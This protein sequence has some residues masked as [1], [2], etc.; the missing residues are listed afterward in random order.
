M[1][2]RAALAAGWLF[3]ALPA[4]AIDV[5]LLHVN[6]VYQM[7]PAADGRG[8]LAR[9]QTL[10]RRLQA[11]ESGRVLFTFGGDTL[12]PSVLGNEFKGAPL[13]AAW[14]AMGIDA[15]VLGNHEFDYGP[16]VLQSRLAESRFPWLA[17]NVDGGDAG[18]PFPGTRPYVIREVGGLRI[19]FVGVVTASTPRVSHPGQDVEF[20]DPL[21][22]ARRLADRLRKRDKVDAVVALTHLDL[23][24]DRRLAGSRKVDLILGGHDHFVVSEVTGGTPIFKAGMDA[25]DAVIARLHF[26]DRSRKLERIE[27]QL[28]PIDA[29]LPEDPEIGALA[30]RYAGALQE[31]LQARIG[32]TETPLDARTSVVRSRESAAGDLVADAFRAAM[33]ADIAIVNGGALRSNSVI[34]PGPLTKLDIKKLLPFENHV[35]RLEISGADLLALLADI[36][37]RIAAG[38]A[39]SFPQVAGLTLS[40]ERGRA[41]GRRLAGAW[42]GGA[43]VDPQRTYSVAVSDFLAAGNDGYDRLRNARRTTTDDAAPVET[44]VVMDYV[45]RQ[46]MLRYSGEGRVSVK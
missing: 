10:H 21:A 27:W 7:D 20:R 6:D 41:A 24:T 26:D 31:A 38:P 22:S 30:S 14:N 29:S 2:G 43:E 19:A 28:Q 12:S 44:D 15:A 37:D 36:G 33:D 3:L 23:A 35:F 16:A 45:Q 13:I 9:L 17:A 32:E 46:P 39:G 42:I 4:W 11:A 1:I 5:V 25:R 18:Q 34:G 40:Y 8:G